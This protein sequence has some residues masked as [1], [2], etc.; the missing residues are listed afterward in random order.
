MKLTNPIEINFFDVI[1]YGKF[2]YIKLGQTKEWIL[3]NFPNP[4]EF[5][6]SDRFFMTKKCNIWTYGD[7]EFFFNKQ[8]EL[9]MIYCDSFN[10]LNGDKWV[11]NEINGGVFLRLDKWIFEKVRKL[12]LPFVIENFLINDI[13]F[14]TKC[15]DKTGGI[16]LITTNYTAS[17]HFETNEENKT[18]LKS[19]KC[20]TVTLLGS[21][22]E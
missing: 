2:D 12:T 19:Y 10:G 11:S 20:S 4:D 22:K 1:K 7:L 9:Y 18:N 3:N 6:E 13:D 14:V 16:E 17:L 15:N 21:L 5:D 8:N